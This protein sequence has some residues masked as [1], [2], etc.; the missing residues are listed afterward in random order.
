AVQALLGPWAAPPTLGLRGTLRDLHV[1]DIVQLKCLAGSTAVVRIEAAADQSG[2]IH[3]QKGQICHALTGTMT[4]MA[5]LEEIVNWPDAR[6]SETGLPV[7]SP[8]TIDAPW[9]MV[10]LQVVRKL[11][12]NSQREPS[13]TAAVPQ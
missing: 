2:E 13:G 9:Q 11:K 10:L 4:R 7:E 8:R 6:L 12:Q 1:V 5:A 3:F